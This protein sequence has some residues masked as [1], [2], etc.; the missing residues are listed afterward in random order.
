[1]KF[2]LMG[3]RKYKRGDKV[4]YAKSKHG[5]RPGPRARSIDPA[6]HGDHYTYFVDKFWTVASATNEGTIVLY[7]RRGKVHV[8]KADHTNLRRA[9]LMERWLYGPRFPKLPEKLS[10]I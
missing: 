9:S 8:L 3:A 5:T 2:A 4:I 10:P 1:M 7:T 6:P